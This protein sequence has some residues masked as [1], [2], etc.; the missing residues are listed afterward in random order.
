MK[1]KIVRI[2]LA[3]TLVFALSSGLLVNVLVQAQP[4]NYLIPVC[5]DVFMQNRDNALNVL[6]NIYD[7][8][9]QN[10][11][12]ETMYPEYYGGLRLDEHGN[13]VLY[14]VSSL[15][16]YAI[17]VINQVHSV[18]GA[19]NYVDFSHNTLLE[20]ENNINSAIDNLLLTDR[21][22]EIFNVLGAWLICMIENRV[23]VEFY[24]YNEVNVN[25]F[26]QHIH[27]SDLIIYKWYYATFYADD[28]LRERMLQ[29]YPNLTWGEKIN[30][31]IVDWGMIDVEESAR[32]N[33]YFYVYENN[34]I[35]IEAFTN[36]NIIVLGT[37]QAGSNG[38]IGFRM[39][40]RNGDEGFV[41]A[42]HIFDPPL[43]NN[44]SVNVSA[45]V[46]GYSNNRFHWFIGGHVNS[47][48]P[49]YDAMFVT[50]ERGVE[51]RNT[52]RN[53]RT[54]L[55]GVFAWNTQHRVGDIVYHLGAFTY[56]SRRATV[57]N[58]NANRTIDGHRVPAVRTSFTHGDTQPGDSGGL[59]YTPMGQ[60]NARVAGIHIAANRL[61]G[62][63]YYVRGYRIVR[64]M[65]LRQT[66]PHICICAEIHPHVCC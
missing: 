39:W 64:A 16:D 12:G 35:G 7:S 66:P 43:R 59:V 15:R 34:Y 49:E 30:W 21:N 40:N 26:K 3:L 14:V 53:G 51:I 27:D 6:G 48:S 62:N 24:E 63:G 17:D 25:L 22:H 46:D 19:V 5:D 56:S 36:N 55:P 50:I 4:N 13:L 9:P 58:S 18:N 20:I 10:R 42:R 52:L 32:G 47:L 28:A 44:A 60:N 33:D 37:S 2:S 31:D 54:V 23:I 38:S 65:G 1:K 61:F 57:S 45:R 41:T 8:F 11:V 29:V